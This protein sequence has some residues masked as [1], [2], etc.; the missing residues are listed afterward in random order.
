MKKKSITYGEF[1][2]GK[3]EHKRQMRRVKEIDKYCCRKFKR[4]DKKYGG[5]SSDC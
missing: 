4:F 2:F 3:K 5:D 1:L